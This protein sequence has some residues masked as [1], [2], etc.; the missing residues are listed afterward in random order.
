M[1]YKDIIKSIRNKNLHPIF[2]LTGDEPFYIDKI[3]EYL[4]ENILKNE[5]KE[6]NQSILYGKDIEVSQI[7]E[8]AKQFPFGS[9]KRVVIVKE[10][11]EIRKIEQLESY[12]DNPQLSTI[13][14]ICYKYKKIDKRKLFGKKLKVKS[15]FFESKKLYENEIPN[16][17]EN[18]VS[19]KGF[20][21]EEKGKFMLTE[22]LGTDLS[23]ISNE[24]DKLILLINKKKI[25]SRDIEDNIGISKE[26]NIFEF[27]EALGSKNIL[28]SYK[29]ANHFASNTRKHPL[30]LI[31]GMLF[32]FFQ[33]IMIYHNISDRRRENLAKKLGV[34]PFFINQYSLAAKNYPQKKLY[35]IFT[36]LKEY[37]LKSKGVN[38]KSTD[39]GEL[40]KELIYKILH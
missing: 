3:S 22:F 20:S 34:N 8:E 38:N 29:I 36:H 4:I 19:E 21:I 6:F 2:F 35:N 7:I 16:W 31:L 30:V 28:K 14:V 26:Y 5:E 33:K 25:T 12:L 18:Y 13:L 15:L 1:N 23:M 27:Q 10:A 11:Q 17:I 32:S 24:L 37:D 39:D 40:L 9:E